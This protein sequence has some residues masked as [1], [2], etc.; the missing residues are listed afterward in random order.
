MHSTFSVHRI[1]IQIEAAIISVSHSHSKGA[2]DGCGT[3]IS[4]CAMIIRPPASLQNENSVATADRQPPPALSECTRMSYLNLLNHSF[5]VRHAE[6]HNNIFRRISSCSLC[7]VDPR[8]PTTNRICMG[9]SFIFKF[10]AVLPLSLCPFGPAYIRLS[11]FIGPIICYHYHCYYV[12]LK[13]RNGCGGRAAVNVERI[14]I[15]SE[16]LRKSIEYVRRPP[17]AAHKSANEHNLGH[18]GFPPFLSKWKHKYTVSVEIIHPQCGFHI[19]Y[20][21]RK[22]ESERARPRPRLRHRHKLN[23]LSSASR[24]MYSICSLCVCVCVSTSREIK[25][26][27]FLFG[28]RQPTSAYIRFK[29][30]VFDVLLVF[31]FPKWLSRMGSENRNVFNLRPE[32]SAL[33]ALISIHPSP[34]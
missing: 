7:L 5:A 17:S 11:P 29:C 14:C 30:N 32:R 28:S 12:M 16:Q 20:H 1:E 13:S 15:D 10:R 6:Y 33:C 23:K 9:I 22:G 31:N 8:R 24:P 19:T 3:I 25:F 18:N 2:L 4:H 34:P 26:C 21:T 27:V